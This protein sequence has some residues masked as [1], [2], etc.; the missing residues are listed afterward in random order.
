MKKPPKPRFENSRITA[1]KHVFGTS[2]VA[3]LKAC[4]PILIFYAIKLFVGLILDL[5]PFTLWDTVKESIGSLLGL[6]YLIPVLR[7]DIL[8]HAQV[9]FYKPRGKEEKKHYLFCW[10]YAAITITMIAIAVNN[11]LGYT[12]LDE[13][14]DGYE[15]VKD[16]FLAGP[17]VI[18]LICLGFIIPYAEEILFRG[19]I[20]G[21][22]KEAFGPQKGIIISALLFGIVHWNLVQ[23]IYATI[24]GLVLAY[25]VEKYRSLIPAY[26]GHAATNIIVVL[27][28]AAVLYFGEKPLGDLIF[29]II[30]L[31]AA[32]TMFGIQFK[33][34]R[35]K[36]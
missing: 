21:R 34:K 24:V 33:N 8:M 17:L 31:A 11:I 12:P 25:F 18:Q 13:M 9:T 22:A 20:Y 32:G 29:T 23:F 28:T 15:A 14:T 26:L 19:I 36:V 10:I 1:I 6:F 30:A 16:A 27:H 35:L 7:R 5:F 3:F 4:Y 2:I